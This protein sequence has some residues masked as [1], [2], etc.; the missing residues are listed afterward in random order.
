M[1][2]TIASLEVKILSELEGQKADGAKV[3]KVLSQVKSQV[4]GVSR[5]AVDKETLAKTLRKLKEAYEESMEG[6]IRDPA[7]RC[8]SC[9]PPS[10]LM[11]K[12]MVSKMGTSLGPRDT[13]QP[14]K[15]ARQMEELDEID[16]EKQRSLPKMNEHEKRK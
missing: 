6:A 1:E 3:K 12:N 15:A 4:S 10:K 7:V 13:I 5:S 11:L 14:K 9:N 2:N 16:G 8:L